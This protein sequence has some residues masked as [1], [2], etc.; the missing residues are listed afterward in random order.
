MDSAE[1]QFGQIG[2]LTLVGNFMFCALVIIVNV[3]VLISSYQ[4]SFWSLF[5][6][7]GSILSFF[8]FFA[9][10]NNL[11]FTSVYG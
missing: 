11:M 9:L 5:L 2:G 1:E 3:K 7:I 10:L 8:A 4:H 6:I